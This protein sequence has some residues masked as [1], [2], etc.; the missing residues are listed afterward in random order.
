VKHWTN[1]LKPWQFGL[2]VGNPE[3]HEDFSRAMKFLERWPVKKIHWVDEK[4]QVHEFA[5]QREIASVLR[6]EAVLVKLKVLRV[7]GVRR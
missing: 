5:L 4:A 1:S 2:S 7:S 3:Q 6:A